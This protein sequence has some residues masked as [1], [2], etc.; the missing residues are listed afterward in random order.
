MSCTSVLRIGGPNNDTAVLLKN[1]L[2]SYFDPDGEEVTSEPLLKL[3]NKYF[4]ASIRLSEL[5]QDLPEGSY[6]EDG[7]IL[8]FDALKCNPDLTNGTSFDGLHTLHDDTAGDLLRLCVGVS[9][10]AWTSEELRGK[11]H[12]DEYSKRILWCL[13]RGYEYCEVDLSRQGQQNGHDD[14][15]KEGFAR[16]IE[17]IQ[18]TVWSSAVMEKRVQQ[19]L[20]QEYQEEKEKVDV[21]VEGGN[22][23]SAYEPPNLEMLGA[24][25]VLPEPDEYIDEPATTE[26]AELRTS[27]KQEERA[28]HELEGLMKEASRIRE[29]SCTGDLSDNERRRRAADAAT[30]MMGLME[31]MGIEDNEEEDSDNETEN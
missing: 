21:D 25:V 18:G 11:K 26:E 3:Q 17:A 31:K 5:I 30:L 2:L 4:S 14:R 6:Q 24:A 22:K 15:D 8:V 20:K 1:A 10:G 28:Y 9:L 12:E 23:E 27:Q 19:K 29:M 16:L 7:I 13:D